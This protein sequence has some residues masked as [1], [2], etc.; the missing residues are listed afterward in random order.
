MSRFMPGAAGYWI[1]AMGGIPVLCLHEQL[2]PKMVQAL[3]Q[4]VVPQ[5]REIGVLP[6]E[7]PDL[8]RR[9]ARQG[10]ACISWHKNFKGKDWPEEDFRQL[11]VPL[12]G[13]AETRG[14]TVTLAEKRVALTNGLNVRQIRRRLDHGRQ[15]PLITTHPHPAV[16]P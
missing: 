16:A 7:A 6:E 14:I 3:E 13:P 10:I 11:K 2:D 4:D 5:L 1:N 9:L 12:Y 15:V 8:F